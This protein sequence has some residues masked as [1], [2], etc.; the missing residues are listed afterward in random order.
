[1]ALNPAGRNIIAAIKNTIII[2][3]DYAGAYMK[4]LILAWACSERDADIGISH[5]DSFIRAFKIRRQ[6]SIKLQNRRI[7]LRKG[8]L[9]LNAAE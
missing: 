8:I 9:N 1:M 3:I 6:R 2:T 4:A 7:R 5:L